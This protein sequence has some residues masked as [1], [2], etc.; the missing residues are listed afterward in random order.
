MSM[1]VASVVNSLAHSSGMTIAMTNPVV[2]IT[3][4]A[5]IAYFRTR[6]ILSSCCEP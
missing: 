5:I 6:I 3:V 2:M 1:S 4:A